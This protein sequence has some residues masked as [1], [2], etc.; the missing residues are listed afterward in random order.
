MQEE[1]KS[2]EPEKMRVGSCRVK[3]FPAFSGHPERSREIQ[4]GKL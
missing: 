2:P 1:S 3:F 4:M